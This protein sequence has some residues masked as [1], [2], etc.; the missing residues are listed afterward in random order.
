M[1]NER[2]LWIL[3]TCFNIN[4]LSILSEIHLISIL[5][6]HAKSNFPLNNSS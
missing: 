2:I 5:L 3:K 4:H 6:S 1:K